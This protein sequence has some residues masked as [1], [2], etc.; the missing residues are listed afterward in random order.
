[1][2]PRRLVAFCF[3]G[4]LLQAQF[5][6]GADQPL[7]AAKLS[8]T[9]DVKQF[10]FTVR[11]PANWSA[12]QE[13][14][15]V[16]VVNAPL[17]RATGKGLDQL[18]QIYVTS[19]QRSDHAAAM[20]R[21]RDLA[22]EYDV[23]ITYFSVGGWPA[24]RRQIVVEKE[25]AGESQGGPAP[26]M[27]LQIT[28]AIAAG[29]VLI[30]EV[31][32]MPPNISRAVQEE[33]RSV[34]AGL[35][36]VHVG[37]P[38]E[39]ERDLEVL[40]TASKPAPLP[41]P[42]SRENLAAVQQN[43][44]AS[45]NL[46]RAPA[47]NIYVPTSGVAQ[48]IPN[49]AGEPEVAVSTDGT[50]V[51]VVAQF[52]YSISTDGGKTFPLRGT[53]SPCCSTGGDSSVAFGKSG[54][55]Y[56]GTVFGRSSALNVLGP[57]SPA[58]VFRTN[59]FTC[60][61]SGPNQCQFT[62]PTLPDQE[63]IG[64]DRFNATS[65]GDQV[66]FVWRMGGSG[67]G[68]FG[69][70]CSTNSGTAFGSPQF[71]TGD[72]PRISVGQDG[73]VYV[74]YEI[75][76]NVELTKFGS[77]QS[78]LGQLNNFPITIATGVN[79]NCPVPGLD[80]CNNGNTL[81]SPMVAVDDQNAAVVFVSYASST[82]GCGT[83]AAGQAGCNENIFVWYSTNGGQSFLP[84]AL[85]AN[86][87][88]VATR[89]FMPW[90][91]AAN[92]KAWVSW[93][94]RRA[95]NAAG[96]TDDL[97]AYYLTSVQPTGSNILSRGA[98]VNL[99]VASDPECASGF[100][101]NVRSLADA[102]SCTKPLPAIVNPAGGCPKYGDYNGSACSSV[103]AGRIYNVWASATAPP[104]LP[105]PTAITLYSSVTDAGS[106]GA[107]GQPCCFNGSTCNANLVCTNNGAGTNVCSCGFSGQPCCQPGGSC[108]PGFSCG[109]NNQ[110]SCGGLEEPCCNGQQCGNGLE[111]SA[112]TATC[113]ST[114]GN[115]GQT[116]CGGTSC[117][118]GLTCVGGECQC[119]S[120]NQPCCIQ[121]SSCNF[122]LVCANDRCS[123]PA[124]SCGQCTQQVNNCSGSCG[125][126][127]AQ[128]SPRFQAWQQCQCNCSNAECSCFRANTCGET[129]VFQ[130]CGTP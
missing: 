17:A 77:C 109:I 115:Q 42:A 15:V 71:F 113:V 38:A 1:M 62:N 117:S 83:T 81:A 108:S 7:Q 73:S 87:P 91:C 103:G 101:C 89:R 31:G 21:L 84:N 64:A 97:T 60:P 5:L 78:G 130:T 116:C 110:C 98:E 36:F 55:F 47:G 9:L 32:M 54:T 66:Y 63:H 125:A 126:Q 118:G 68:R 121:G 57:N 11:Y 127:P 25:Q 44:V 72:F 119:G 8:R 94:D 76:G 96:A 61:A 75:G 29:D 111:C 30:R 90:V 70:A 122:N 19:E 69:I 80:R 49:L 24:L 120:L 6:A 39:T 37:I 102:S 48:N 100:G 2:S 52:N 22:L 43:A 128:N 58:F 56:E 45:G 13:N 16:W 107:V 112:K 26:Q 12:T 50:K 85:V 35:S 93:Y 46:P 53:F 88:A 51:V 86:N 18:A 82:T 28:T 114:C 105:I 106:C 129:C 40:R 65:T 14:G 23:P 33:V 67:S 79:V 99:S 27:V 3:V 104:G 95:A 4:L 92:G 34:Q 74:V 59:A 41:Q 20:Q 10:G 123:T 124:S